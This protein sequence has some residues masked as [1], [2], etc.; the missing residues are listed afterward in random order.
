MTTRRLLALAVFSSLC[1]ACG[2]GGVDPSEAL[3]GGD[4]TIF[5]YGDEAFNYPA[6][7]LSDD[8][9][10][11][12]QI[13]DGVFNRNWVAA[14]SSVQGSDGLGP[15][16][17][18]VGCSGC[19]N[20]NGR[21]ATPLTPDEP[22]LGLLLRLSVPGSDAVTGG[23]VPDPNYGDQL[24]PYAILGVPGEG[25]PSVTYVETAGSFPDGAAYSLR[26]PSYAVGALAFGPLAQDA[27]V[28]P[29]LAPQMVGLGLLQAVD[30]STIAGFAA[31]NGGK[32][33]RVWDAQSQTTLLG[34]FG[35]KANQPGLQQQT[36]AA[37]RNDIGITSALFPTE[38]CPPVQTACAAAPMSLTEPNLEPV[39]ANAMEVH[40]LG[41]GVPAR[42]DLDDPTAAHGEKL[43]SQVGCAACH[44]PKMT[45][46]TLDGWPELSNQ[47]IRPFT[48]LLLHDMG[49][50]LADGRPDFLA[51]GSEFR[52]PPLW[53][54]GLADA[55]NGYLFLMHDGRARGF[56][57]AI[58]WHGG[59]A[60]ESK[61]AFVNL[62]SDDRAAL[63]AF[64][65]TL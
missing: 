42:R 16:Y 32:M 55:I 56:Q 38:N 57:E 2:G 48:D 7:N 46:G 9:R 21:G 19:H 14:P 62:S 17:N 61:Q 37:F 30:E 35:W 6:R 45:T 27:M 4:G 3:L 33:N 11:P 52:T 18:A 12:F 26:T 23:P 1:A 15:T 44:I 20:N 34:R 59:Q 31:Q 53:G 47:T 40:A 25:T 13:G 65:Q 22:F 58:V 63:I 54:L 41:L 10:G 28:A 64:L 39:R 60:E 51:S 49:A 50:A 24:Q 36:Y 43:F 29:R 5:D 8:K